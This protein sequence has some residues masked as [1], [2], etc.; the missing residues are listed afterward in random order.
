MVYWKEEKIGEDK[1]TI[2]VNKNFENIPNSYIRA[3]DE[4]ISSVEGIIKFTL[5]EPDFDVPDLVKEAAKQAVDD[6]YSHYGPT[7]GVPFYREEI[8]SYLKRHYDLDYD[9]D[10]NIIVTAGVSQG[11]SNAAHALLNPG[12]KVI[13]SSPYFTMYDTTIRSAYGEL[14]EVD[15]SQEG[16]K[17][18]P[19]KL[20]QVLEQEDNVK[21]V[22]LNY[23]NNPTGV[24]YTSDELKNLAEVIEKHNVYCVSDEVYSALTYDGF[25]HTSIARFIPDRTI[26]LNGMSKAY[27][28]TGYR[29]GYM[30][31]PEDIY[32]TFY[33]VHQAA[34]TCVS[35][36]A[37]IAGAVALRDGDEEV[38]KM[39]RAY[40][41]RRN[42]LIPE[43]EKL[44]FEIANPN[45]AFY[46]FIKIPE[47]LDQ[48][49]RKF[50]LEIAKEARVGL[51]PGEAFGEHGQGYL[52]M[53]Y[54]SSMEALEE[55]IRRL[56]DYLA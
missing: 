22:L 50:A 4:E 26:L 40:A 30:A 48:D 19:E 38:E 11:L 6:N 27:A 55:G 43:L 17:F 35:T 13:V 3:F 2:G 15:T 46:L 53:S 52:R 33:V 49:S 1:M 56:N 23:P 41:T 7:N 29:L 20:D 44:G 16:F 28:M 45:G 21:Y 18:T 37:Q 8:C 10:K 34:L 14:V 31:I 39:R 25:K 5:G 24:S 54:A 9:P 47:K 51:I 12:E 42:F 36:P 32:Q